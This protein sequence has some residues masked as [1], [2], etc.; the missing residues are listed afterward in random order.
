MSGFIEWEYPC[1]SCNKLKAMLDVGRITENIHCSD[2]GYYSNKEIINDK[3][4][5]INKGY[6]VD[7]WTDEGTIDNHKR[8]TIS[9][10]EYK[11]WKQECIKQKTGHKPFYKVNGKR[12]PFVDDDDLPF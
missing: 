5:T 12:T 11:D 2:C 7:T 1:P 4:V 8:I 10:D 9:I 3:W 6:V